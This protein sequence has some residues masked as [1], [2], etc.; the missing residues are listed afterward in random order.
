MLD[1]AAQD[2]IHLLE[3]R[4][5][6]K[7]ELERT[8][9]WEWAREEFALLEGTRWADEDPA[10]AFL[11]IKGAR[12]LNRR[13]LAVLRELVP[14]RD[15][16]AARAR[17]RDVPRARQR[18]AARRSRAAAARRARRSARSRECR[19]AFSSRAA[20]RCSTRCSAALAVPEAE[21]PRFPKARALGSRSGFR[22]ARER[23]QD[24]AR[25]G[26]HAPR[27]RSRRALLARPDGSRRAPESGD[28]RRAR[29]KSRSC[30]AGSAQVLG[31]EFVKALAPHRKAAKP[32]RR[33]ASDSAVSRS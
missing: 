1:Y 33:R 2:T 25:R 21:L 23:A 13:E 6:L 9:R 16:V 20:T 29:A 5:Q 31:E 4:D 32:R 15:G 14:W 18:A 11:R 17:S 27:S 8:G 19:A 3:L 10:T 24:R 7:D 26:G 28:G 22:R 30:D 12:D